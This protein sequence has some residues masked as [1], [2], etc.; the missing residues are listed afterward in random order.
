MY[1]SPLL[2]WHSQG[3]PKD[4]LFRWKPQDQKGNLTGLL[5]LPVLA[6]RCW[7]APTKHAEHCPTSDQQHSCI[8]QQLTGLQTATYGSSVLNHTE[9][10]KMVRCFLM[11][12][13]WTLSNTNQWLYYLLLLMSLVTFTFKWTRPHNAEKWRKSALG[14]KYAQFKQ[15]FCYPFLI[16]WK[17]C[18]WETCWST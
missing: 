14:F 16:F 6:T 12:N 1:P 8:C 9:F 4:I 7:R 5:P 17:L 11:L 10:S 2:A 13:T 15:C 18:F 3:A